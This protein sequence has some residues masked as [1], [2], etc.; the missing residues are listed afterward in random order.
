MLLTNRVRPTSAPA[1][2]ENQAV[3][4]GWKMRYLM[5]TDSDLAPV[6]SRADYQMLE[7]DMTM[8]AD[9]FAPDR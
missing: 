8:P 3:A 6:R 4:A 5:R 7:L 9:T 1:D 2:R